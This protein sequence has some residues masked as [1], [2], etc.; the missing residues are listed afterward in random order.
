MIDNFYIREASKEDAGLIADLSRLTFYEAFISQ[1]TK[2]NMDKFLKEQ[3]T[4]KLLMQEVGAANN[5]FL[6]AY[7]EK[8]VAGY[9]RLREHNIPPGLGTINALEIA[10]IYAVT[11]MIGKGVGSALMQKSIDI[12]N[13]RK[14]ECVWLG[15]WKK[16]HRAILFYEKWGFEKFAE[17]DFIL[18]DD[19][20]Q[21]WL[22]KKMI[23]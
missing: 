9:V 17:H 22:M 21:D 20:Q 19:M 2:A 18:G 12:A 1:N 7:H 10:R 4:K 6:L 23:I 5:T 16:N 3:F 13:E 14:K 8:E 11:S 15:V